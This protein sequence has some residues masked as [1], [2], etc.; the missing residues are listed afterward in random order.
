MKSNKFVLGASLAILT[1]CAAGCKDDPVVSGVTPTPGED[2]NFGAS[3]GTQTRTV[4]GDQVDNSFPIYWENGDEVLIMSPGGAVETATYSI[5]APATSDQN[6]ASGMNKVGDVGVRWGDSETANFYSVYPAGQIQS[7]NPTQNTM[8]LR[9][10]HMQNDYI[11]AEAGASNVIAKADMKG[12]FLY[13]QTLDV[14]NGTTPVKLAYKPLAT[15]LRFKL[16]GPSSGQSAQAVESEVIISN[17]RIQAPTGTTIAGNFDVKFATAETDGTAATPEI[18]NVATV[19]EDNGFDYVTIYSSYTGSE[20]GGYLTLKTHESITLN[21]FLIPRSNLAI[22]DDWKIIV[23]LS[24]GRTLTRSLG[25]TATEGK[26][27]TLAPGKIH[28]L[29]DLPELN[30]PTNS[31]YDPSNWMVN[32]P[33]NTYLSEISIPGSW[34]SLNPDAQ[35]SNPSI[36]TQYAN[37]VR[38]FHLD[39]RWIGNRNP[40]IGFIDGYFT[41]GNVTCNA[42]GIA[43]SSTSYRVFSGATTNSD[44]LGRVM[45]TNAPTFASTFSSVTNNVKDDEYMVV[46][47]TFAQGS[48]SNPTTSW[49]QAISELC[50]SNDKVYD[51]K[52]LTSKTVVGDVLGKVIV[53]ICM[54]D[55]VSDMTELSDSKCLFTQAPLTLTQ[56]MFSGATGTNDVYQKDEM[57]FGTKTSSG[58]TLYNT[59]AQICG[60]TSSTTTGDRGYAPSLSERQAAG[61]NILNWSMNNYQKSDY[62]SSNWI[63]L[64]IGGYISNGNDYSTVATSMNAWI[65]GKVTNMNARPSGTQ[66]SYYPVGIVLMNQVSSYT[67]VVNNILQLNNKYQKAYNP[68]WTG[69]VTGGGGS[70]NSVNSLSENHQSAYNQDTEN[71]SV[72]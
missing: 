14:N 12:G 17:I 70:Q 37:G 35:G 33:R 13:A 34:N 40:S 51:A 60:N 72:F 11:D 25:G 71:W 69:D 22:S 58:I 44:L 26:N 27:M 8:T 62:T 39:T 42:L 59:Q 38:A 36:A 19:D 28:V 32:I 5:D 9:L 15:A 52:Q 23:T 16:Q 66:T 54:E 21:A 24:D 48:Y 61:N 46:I 10:P 56:S 31:E 57:Y 47:C 2:V 63:Y 6:Y 4:Y 1:L 53:I 3:L 7:S 55:A 20:G 65:N 29:P 41:Y 45:N 67:D 50:A 18:T 30:I 43:D 64:G 68:D 49:Y